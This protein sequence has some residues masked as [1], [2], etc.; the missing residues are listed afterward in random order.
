MI[1]HCDF[2]M[3]CI[4]HKRYHVLTTRDITHLMSLGIEWEKI[5]DLIP[6]IGM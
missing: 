1:T 4:S 5:C 3:I 2:R 6:D